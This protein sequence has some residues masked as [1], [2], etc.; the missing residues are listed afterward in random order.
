MPLLWLLVPL[1]FLTPAPSGAW[2]QSWRLPVPDRGTA[3][4]FAY[5]RA[6]PF[7]RGQRRGVDLV[8][9]PGAAVRSACGGRVTHAGAVPRFGR[10]VTIRCGDLAATELG[11][12]SVAV[13]RGD[14]VLPGQ[15][16]GTAG[17]RGAVRLGAR[18]SDDRWG[19]V[20]PSLLVRGVR[21]T[22]PLL[23]AGRRAP[24]APGAVA[25]P[26]GRPVRSASPRRAPQPVGVAALEGGLDV[27]ALLVAL[28]ATLLLVGVPLH[29]VAGRMRPRG[30][31][32]A[33]RVRATVD[34]TA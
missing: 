16:I 8:V 4:P 9:R 6:H 14:V 30:R 7:A 23:P 20:D 5:D 34:R 1:V 12:A 3:A 32:A 26:H 13:S 29:L 25:R 27:V 19:W 28:G 31:T 22:S 2:G 11:L 17:P 10:G 15:A 21:R 18:R 33:R 24:R